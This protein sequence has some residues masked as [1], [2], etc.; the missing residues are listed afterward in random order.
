MRINKYIAQS[1]YCSRRQADELIVAGRVLVNGETA[2]QGQQVEAH[3]IVTIGTKRI[4]NETHKI[5]LAYHKPVGI[6]CTTDTSKRDNIIKAVNYPNRIF[7]VGRLDVA[8]SGLILLTN[9]GDFSELVTGGDKRDEHGKRNKIEKEYIVDVDKPITPEF[10]DALK[11]GITILGQVTLPAKAQKLGTKK[12]RI[13]LVQGLNRQI[14]RMC[15]VFDYKVKHLQRVRIGEILLGDLQPGQWR[16]IT[17][18]EIG[19]E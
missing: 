18:Q 13:V 11:K 7:P 12:F 10:I 16:E 6:M 4:K 17:K 5:Y 8:S 15:E 2:V 19:I 14:R 1:G 3:D 9:D